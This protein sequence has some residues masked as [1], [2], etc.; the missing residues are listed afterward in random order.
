MHYKCKKADLN[1]EKINSLEGTYYAKF[2]K[3]IDKSRGTNHTFQDLDDKPR[4]QRCCNHCKND[5]HYE[6][7]CYYQ[8]KIPNN[9]QNMQKKSQIECLNCREF[10]H[11]SR[12]CRMEEN[13]QAYMHHEE[14]SKEVNI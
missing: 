12:D 9:D 6:A 3:A 11:I 13:Q 1:M 14:L 10:R 2:K 8:N 5:T 4:N 7:M